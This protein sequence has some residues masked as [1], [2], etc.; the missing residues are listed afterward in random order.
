MRHLIWITAA[1]AVALAMPVMAQDLD[2][3]T[4]SD[5]FDSGARGNETGSG[6][7]GASASNEFAVIT[8][9]AGVTGSITYVNTWAGA[10]AG[11][12]AHAESPVINV[13]VANDNPDRNLPGAIEAITANANDSVSPNSAV[14]IGDD[15]GF[16]GLFLGEGD[17]SNCF[18]Q[19]DVYCE[20]RTSEGT[21]VYEALS[22]ALRA[23][24]DPVVYEYSY[25]VDRDGSYSL[26]YDAQLGTVSARK[27]TVGNASG[28][29][30][31]RVAS[32]Y[33][34]F[35]SQALTEGWHTFRVEGYGSQIIFS[36]DNVEL[37]SV[38]DT[39]FTE[40]R[41]GLAYREASIDNADE[42]QGKFDN[43]IAGPTTAPPLPLGT[44]AFEAE[45]DTSGI[46]GGPVGIAADSSGGICFVTFDGATS[47]LNYIA[48]PIGAPG[49]IQ[50]IDTVALPTGRGLQDVEVDSAGYV[51]ICGDDG[52]TATVLRRYG[53]APTFTPDATFNANTAASARRHSGIAIVTGDP[54]S[55]E[56]I[57]GNFTTTGDIHFYLA[58]DGTDVGSA[59]AAGA[60]TFQRDPSFNA[61]NSDIYQSHNGA[62]TD[63]ISLISGGDAGDPST[64]TQVLPGLLPSAS[65]PPNTAGLGTDFYEVTN[66]LIARETGLVPPAVQLYDI[67]GSGAS[68]TATLNQ[69]L[70]FAAAPG[71]D[72]TNPGDQVLSDATDPRRLFV[73]DFGS[74][75]II[76][77][78]EAQTTS[79]ESFELYR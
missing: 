3:V 11:E 74:S 62:G 60:A 44:Y 42:S 52:G 4:V 66:T 40:G 65:T 5:T 10:S 59:V 30:A 6:T 78:S 73:S 72:I 41:P 12:P 14:L 19:A 75:R 32:T 36:V 50:T 55:P 20:D 68:T 69:T 35:A 70:S 45:I 71:G 18:I 54:G 33:T 48:D 57:M 13:T 22:V 43:L 9:T 79:V 26:T 7:A 56:L 38:T 61:N 25:S 64:Y 47:T 77:F 67:S 31:S 28:D 1:V 39:E 24:H 53:P 8:D 2:T 63:L 15:G 49:T 27:W 37:V 46:S 58:S 76:V 21:T 23:G 17:D 51:Y 16:N 34:E 29:I